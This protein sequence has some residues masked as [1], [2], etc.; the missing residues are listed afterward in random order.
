MNITKNGPVIIT[1]GGRPSRALASYDENGRL[2]GKQRSLV[3]ALARPGLSAIDFVRH[4]VEIR[5]R[6]VDLS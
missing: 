6:D 4:R 2:T 1:D 3:D 5:R